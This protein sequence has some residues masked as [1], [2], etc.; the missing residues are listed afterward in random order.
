MQARG[1]KF[2]KQIKLSPF[3]NVNVYPLLCNL[4]EIDCKKNNGS[5]D[6]F[7]SALKNDVT[8]VEQSLLKLFIYILI[9]LMI[10]L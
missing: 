3:E 4:L 10:T 9:C 1:P 7:K 5:V 2:K 6:V 8:F